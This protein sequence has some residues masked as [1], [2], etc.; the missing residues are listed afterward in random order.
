MRTGVV[1]AS[2][3][4]GAR[5]VGA[6]QVCA[7]LGCAWVVVGTGGT[8]AIQGWCPALGVRVST[9]GCQGSHCRSRC[10]NG[11]TEARGLVSDG[12]AGCAPVCVYL[13][14][15][16]IHSCGEGALG[17]V[18]VCSCGWAGAHEDAGLGVWGCFL[19]VHTGLGVGVQLHVGVQ[20]C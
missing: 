16:G 4:V 12:D 7:G 8:V 9:E 14:L 3:I 13:W 10:R 5:C 20:P 11:E 17:V 19:R 1:W 6:V 18:W 15:C 2:R